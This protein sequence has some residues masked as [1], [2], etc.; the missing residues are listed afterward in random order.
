MRAWYWGDCECKGAD[1]LTFAPHNSQ[2]ATDKKGLFNGP[3]RVRVNDPS[4]IQVL[5]HLFAKDSQ[6]VYYIMGTAKAVVDPASFEVLPEPV[7]PGV[8]P[9]EPNCGYARDKFHVYFAYKMSGAPKVLR[10]ADLDTFEVVG[11]GRAKDRQNVWAADTIMKGADPAT[12]EIINDLYSKDVRCVYYDEAP[13]PGS[14]PK[15]FRVIGR[16]TGVDKSNVFVFRERIE[17]ADPLT[18]RCDDD[19]V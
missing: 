2:W 18:Y 13:L 14:D 3:K 1:S 8:E 6:Q 12:F 11:P 19:A 15:T 7:V 17:G 9:R 16:S 10:K 4:T 5:N